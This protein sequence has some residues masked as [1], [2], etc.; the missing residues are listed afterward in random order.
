[1]GGGELTLEGAEK[2]LAVGERQ[3]NAKELEKGGQRGGRKTIPRSA[4][5]SAFAG[6]PRTVAGPFF[7]FA[8]V[9]APD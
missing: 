1:M 3:I 2:R 8:G 4:R 5:E 6:A 7:D 9:L